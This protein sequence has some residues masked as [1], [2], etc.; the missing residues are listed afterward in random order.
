VIGL[1]RDNLTHAIG[2]I[3]RVGARTKTQ[4][5]PP[6]VAK[7]L[8]ILPMQIASSML[9]F[10]LHKYATSRTTIESSS[11]PN[12]SKSTLAS[13]LHFTFHIPHISL[14]ISNHVSRFQYLRLPGNR[15]KC[16]IPLSMHTSIVLSKLRSR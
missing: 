15:I 8:I 9:V 10:Y 13:S 6:Q 2:R 16:H 1:L 3:L 12:S 11:S 14:S 5:H 4:P 7:P